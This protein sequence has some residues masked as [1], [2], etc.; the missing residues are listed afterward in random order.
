MHI[1]ENRHVID[2]LFLIALLGVFTISAA[3]L[4]LSGTNIYRNIVSSMDQNY[5]TRTSYAYLT[6]RLHSLDS[7]DAISI[8]TVDSVP[9]ICITETINDADY[10]TLIYAY[11]GSIRELF[12]SVGNDV[13]LSAGQEIMACESFTITQVGSK[14]YTIHLETAEEEALNLMIA[15]HSDQSEGTDQ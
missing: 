4:I 5:D 12:T 7:S 15:T 10:N 1:D 11:D 9:V 14:L 8:Q 13:P 2:I 3:L 6:Q